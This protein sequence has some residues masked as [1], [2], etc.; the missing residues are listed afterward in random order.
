[1]TLSNMMNFRLFFLG[2]FSAPLLVLGQC[3]VNLGDDVLQCNGNPVTLTPVYSGG[4]AQ[5]SLRITYDATQGV[6]GLVGASEVYFHSGIQTVP[7]G[8]WE[9]TVGNWGMNDGVGQM[10][11]LGNNLWQITIHVASYYGYPGGTNVNGL[12]MVFRNGDGSAT[13]K[14]DND[15]DIFLYTSNGNTCDFG[16]VTGTD[17]P[18]STGSFLWSTNETTTSI[19]V[20]QTGTYSVTFTDGL[21]CQSTDNV[22][23]T[24]GAGSV[25][26]N[27]GADTSLCDGETITLDAGSGFASYE[28]STSET[29]QTLQVDQPGDYS[30]TVTDQAG[31]T[32]IDL[33]HISTGTSPTADFSYN[34]TVGTTVEFTDIGSGATTV[35]WDFNGDGN[36]DE[37]T[38]G[39][40][41]VQYDFGAESV[42]GVVMISENGCGTDTS[43]QNVLVHDVGIEELKGQIGLSVYPNPATDM[44]RVSVADSRVSVNDMVLLDVQGRVVLRFPSA[45]SNARN[46]QLAPLKNGVYV[47][48]VSTSKGIIN[49]RILKL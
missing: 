22:Q 14:D 3:S 30:V 12:W 39:G 44:V 27:L 21:G 46:L 17:I 45:N 19:T 48:R 47:L 15:G 28:W 33:I 32:G 36:I 8:G 34:A 16:G 25:Q 42:F 5:D 43:S 13:G 1:M 7:F 9:Y 49:E 40:A 29:S 31:C 4:V 18:G 26:V 6:T 11:P 24:F 10:T 23:V 38:A 20:T 41:S 35:Y 2:L 37:T